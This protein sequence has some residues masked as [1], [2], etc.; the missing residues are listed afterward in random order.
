MPRNALMPVLQRVEG[1]DAALFDR[2]ASD[3]ISSDLNAV[4]RSTRSSASGL[5]TGY[6]AYAVFDGSL[7]NSFPFISIVCNCLVA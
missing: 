6:I 3:F 4:S 5:T 1:N 2:S 7:R